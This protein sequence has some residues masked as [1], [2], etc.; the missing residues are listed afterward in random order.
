MVRLAQNEKAPL[1]RLADKYSTYFTMITL[2]IAIIGF[3]FAGGLVGILAVLVVATPCPLILATPIALLGGVN[4]AAK[5]R[6]IVKRL[7]SLESLARVQSIVFDKTG[8]ITIGKPQVTEVLLTN[9]KLTKDEVISIAAAIERNSLHPLAKAIVTYSKEQKINPAIVTNIKEIIGEGIKADFQ[10]KKYMVTKG[11]TEQSGGISLSVLENDKQIALIH[12]ADEIKPSSYEII[13][14]L[15]AQHVEMHIFTGDRKTEAERITKQL[16]SSVDVSAEMTPEEKKQG[17]ENLQKQGKI[18]AMLGDGI[19]DAPALALA[20]VGL[21]F[22]SEEQTAA[23]EAADIVL[24]GGDFD[25]V[26]MTFRIAKKTV[27]IAL[28]SI[29]WGIGLS[30]LCMIF[31]AFG[32]IPP[33]VGAGIQEAIDVAVIINALRA[34]RIE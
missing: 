33:I 3:F 6:I 25:V 9:T 19:N 20:D 15:A 7:A 24:L 2:V 1:V 27:A 4:A 23:S 22:S 31:A 16:G 26:F 17:I 8:T 32:F 14:R 21:V 13:Q 29:R 18:V 28:Q 11:N 12:L 30:I 10:E 5:K 34:S